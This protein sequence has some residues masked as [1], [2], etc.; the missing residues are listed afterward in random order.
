MDKNQPREENQI[1]ISDQKRQIDF[2]QEIDDNVQVDENDK[3]PIKE[4]QD[5]FGL[6][7]EISAINNNK[8]IKVMAT[9]NLQ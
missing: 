3:A 8:N 9:E 6:M 1:I 5:Y 2:N 4:I 7:S